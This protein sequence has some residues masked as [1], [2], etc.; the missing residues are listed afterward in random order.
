MVEH[1]RLGNADIAFW[2]E[3]DGEPILLVHASFGADWF[4]P[5]ARMLPEYRVLRTHRAGYGRSRDLSHTLGLAD[6]AEHLAEVLGSTGIEQAHVVGHSSGATIALQ[7]AAS[8]P[9]L[10][11]SM[12]LLEPA[13][14]AAPDEPRGQVIADA[15]AAARSG[16]LDRAFD[17]FL[18]SVMSPGYRDVLSRALGVAGLAESVRS[19]GYFFE[20]E[21]AA[22]V[23]WDAVGLETLEQPALLVDGGAGEYLGS[24]YRARNRALAGRLRNAVRLTLPGLSHALPLEN[25][26]L[27]A[28]TIRDFVGRYP[29]AGSADAP[30]V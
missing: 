19:G 3:G 17:L 20:C 28:R 9:R 16:D 13:A 22:L 29:I 23:G 15:I 24:P 4:A 5:V 12:V 21:M 25:P 6:H 11:R 14:P 10:V 30:L 7:L 26:C 8:H 27:V 2:D 1:L 18:G